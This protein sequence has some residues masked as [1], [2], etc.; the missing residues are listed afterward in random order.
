MYPTAGAV[1]VQ[2]HSSELPRIAQP[3]WNFLIPPAD[4]KVNHHQYMI[5]LQSGQW[6]L[7]G[8]WNDQLQTDWLQADEWHPAYLRN[9][10]TKLSD[11]DPNVPD[12]IGNGTIA[13]S[14]GEGI[15]VSGAGGTANQLGN[16]DQKVEV[17]LKTDGGIIIDPNGNGLEIDWLTFVGDGDILIT[18]DKG[19][20]VRSNVGDN[21][22]HANQ[23]CHS[24]TVI[25]LS[26]PIYDMIKDGAATKE[27][28]LDKNFMTF[29]KL[30]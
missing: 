26:T 6:V 8:Q 14:G 30:Y 27:L 3:S 29:P 7:C 19:I 20:N 2:H 18:G 16:T 4:G 15:K 11:I 5:L 25:E 1:A 24:E 23:K 12:V 28:K 21:P 9:K 10:P 13:V 22:P 17:D